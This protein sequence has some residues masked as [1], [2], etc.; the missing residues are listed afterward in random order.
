MDR[1]R[2]V[3]GT[4]TDGP[5]PDGKRLGEGETPTALPYPFVRTRT[6]REEFRKA[7]RDND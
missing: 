6:K 5:G 1:W 3:S 7:P 4:S 2:R